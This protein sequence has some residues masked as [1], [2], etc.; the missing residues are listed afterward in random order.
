VTLK[1][2]LLIVAVLLAA[3]SMP[4]CAGDYIFHQVRTTILVAD[5]EYTADLIT[6][7]AE[8]QGGYCIYRSMDR[9]VL[10][11]PSQEMSGIRRYLEQISD[12]VIEVSIQSKDLREQLVTL[13]SRIKSSEEIL[14][15][16]LEYL[17]RTDVKGTLAIEKEVRSLLLELENY[18]GSLRKLE[19]DRQFAYYELFLSFKEQTLPQDI[20]SSFEW[21]NRVDF[22]RFAEQGAQE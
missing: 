16:N 15:R 2:L 14:A 4:V 21:I 11:V 9:I 20:P 7:W 22:Y 6:E 10:R 18:K 12:A 3:G 17:D 8:E 1:Y 19:F 5:T 13:R